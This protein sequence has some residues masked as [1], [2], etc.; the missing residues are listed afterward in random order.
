[1]EKK[2]FIFD[3][4]GTLLVPDWNYE[5]EYFSNVLDK[6]SFEKFYPMIPDL[7]KKYEQTHRKYNVE[8]LSRFL[9]IK[10]G[11]SIS[12]EII[13]GWNEALSMTEPIVIDGVVDTFEYLKSKDKSI[14]VL[15]N[16]FLTPQIARL[17]K[18]GLMD[19]LDF[20]YGGEFGIKPNPEVYRRACGEFRKDLSVVIGDSLDFDVYGPN[21]AGIDSIY[22]N[23]RNNDDFDK[24]KVKSIGNMRKIKEMF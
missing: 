10:S 17:K 14:V 24:Q 1:M 18:S 16:W 12:P 8:E 4:D 6:D 11:V 7:L 9:S 21:E 23:P 3:I 19:Y 15:T 13:I 5:R 2:R 22:Y 20:V